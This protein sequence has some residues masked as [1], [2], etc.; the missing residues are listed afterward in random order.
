MDGA[1]PR[2]PFAFGA[3]PFRERA[4]TKGP[5]HALESR[6]GNHAGGWSAWNTGT[7]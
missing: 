6:V 7:V 4:K 2:M 5:R 3:P 1:D